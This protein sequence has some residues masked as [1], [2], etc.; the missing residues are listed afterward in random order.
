MCEGGRDRRVVIT[1][2]QFDKRR[3]LGNVAKAA[4]KKIS[5]LSARNSYTYLSLVKQ[6]VVLAT[7]DRQIVDIVVYIM[8]IHILYSLLYNLV[9]VIH[10]V[11]LSPSYSL[12]LSTK[13]CETCQ[14]DKAGTS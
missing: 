5:R 3:S 4:P 10:Y 7:I 2:A 6:G 1:P 12:M 13:L 11:S 8:H 14:C 9:I